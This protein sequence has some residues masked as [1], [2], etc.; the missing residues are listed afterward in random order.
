MFVVSNLVTWRSK[1]LTVVARLSA[2]EKFQ[3]MAHGIHELLWL[4]N[5]LNDLQRP[6]TIVIT[7][8]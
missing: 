1:K 2:K 4:K 7:K 6:M 5:L 8:L 3:F